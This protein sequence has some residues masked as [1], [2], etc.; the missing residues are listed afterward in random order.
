PFV[1]SSGGRHTRFS[2]DWSSD[3]CS[4][5]LAGVGIAAYEL[6]LFGRVQSLKNAALERYLATD[7]ARK[8]AQ[9]SL[10]AEVADAYFTWVA[11]TELKSLADSTLQ[12]RQDSYD[13][14]RQRYESGLASELDLSQAATAL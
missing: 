5:D 3:V 10:V 9:L 1:F 6:D 7:E 12:A 8:S 4:S 14:V 13:M 2:R 11:N